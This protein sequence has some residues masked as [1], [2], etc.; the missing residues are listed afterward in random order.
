VQVIY[1]DHLRFKIRVRQIP[2]DLPERIY[3]E[4]RQR[5]YNHHSVR[6]IAVMETHY[7]R[8]RILMMIAY[9]QLLDHVEIITIHPITKQQ[10]QDRLTTGRWTYEQA[11]SEL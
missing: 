5:Y 7:Q 6:H 11:N 9:D 2:E 1:S 4:S 10:I 8:R 3:R